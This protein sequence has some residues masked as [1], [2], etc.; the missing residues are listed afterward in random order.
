[1]LRLLVALHLLFFNLYACK[2]G[3]DSCRQKV[4]DSESIVEQTI[5]VPLKNNPK[6]SFF[7]N[8]AQ[9]KNHQT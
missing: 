5:Q 1:V 4:I 6:I 3:L 7:Y 2:D 8:T 9:S